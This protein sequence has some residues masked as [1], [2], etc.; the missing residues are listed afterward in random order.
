MVGLHGVAGVNELYGTAA[1]DA[2]LVQA[3]GRIRADAD[4]GDV[5]ARLSGQRFAVLTG[6]LGAA[7][8]PAGR[9]VRRHGG[10]SPTT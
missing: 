5:V 8:L 10:R 3:A 9:P 2:I 1:G 7:R 4:E 6:V